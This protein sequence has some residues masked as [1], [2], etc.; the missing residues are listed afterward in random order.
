MQTKNT[1][2]F[3]KKKVLCNLVAGVNLVAPL[4]ANDEKIY[5]TT[6]ILRGGT[7]PTKILCGFSNFWPKYLR[8]EISEFIPFLPFSQK[9]RLDIDKI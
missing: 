9:F 2:S 3:T 5:L 1:C 8:F 6:P 4:T 7:N